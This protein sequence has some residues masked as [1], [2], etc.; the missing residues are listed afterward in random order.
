MPVSV[1]SL[2]LGTGGAKAAVF[3]DD[4]ICVA[5]RIV[6]YETFYPSSL[7]HEQRPQ[8]WWNAV[9]ASIGALLAAPQ[10]DAGSIKAVVLSGQSLGCIPLDEDNQL[11]ETFVPI[12]SDGRAEAEANAFFDSVDRGDW[13]HMTG[14]GFPPPLYTLFK[15]LW[16][17]NHEPDVF[18]RARTIIGSKDYINFRL[19]GRILTDQS[20][21]SGSGVY[22]LKARR[23][24]PDLLAA[25]GLDARLLPRIVASTDTIGEIL[26]EAARFLDLPQGVKVIAGGVDNGCMAL[27]ASTFAEGDSFLAMGSSSWINVSSAEP[28]LDGVVKPYVFDHVVPGMYLSATSIFSSGTSLKWVRDKLMQDIAQKAEAEGQDAYDA[29]TELA[30]SVSRGAKGLLF[31][32]TLGGGT[33]FEG[34][35][36]VRGGFVGLGLQHGRAEIMRATFEGIALALRVALDELRHMRPLRDEI[37]MVGGGARSAPWRQILAD[38]LGCTVLKTT[39]DQQA[40]ALGAAALAFVGLGRWP[41]FS[42]LRTLTATIERNV[43]DPAAV[44]V[45]EAALRAFRVAARQQRELSEPIS[46]LRDISL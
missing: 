43:P 27:G 25:A 34:G 38:I 5:D 36:A 20:Y 32:P 45:Y 9:A 18:L 2:D 21:A 12:W 7:R 10:V 44:P 23:Y 1:I 4:G 30:L 31:V 37:V 46:A 3:R 8:D 26:P 11:L 24:S 6:A 19:T 17:R 16:L 22:D 40:A 35:P 29:I 13:Y 14:N 33:S 39:I 28:L 41:D 42:R 15:I